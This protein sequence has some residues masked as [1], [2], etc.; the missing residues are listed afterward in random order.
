[1]HYASAR[2]FFNAVREAAI[3][4]ERCRV[5]LEELEERAQSLGGTTFEAR[6][7]GG[8]H[9]R[10]ERNAVAHV[11]R[12]G[13]L[14]SR[15]EDDYRLIDAACWVLYG[16]DGVSDGLASIAPPWWADAIYHHY[17][18]L[19]KW[20]DVEPLVLACTSHISRCVNAAFDLMDA[21]GMLATIEGRGTAAS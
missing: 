12:E 21:N 13:E 11:D 6:V 4:A 8:T 9:D 16:R 7:R 17:L 20:E 2:E 19:R 5:Q 18:A 14:Q 1:M 3:D 15:I 10:M